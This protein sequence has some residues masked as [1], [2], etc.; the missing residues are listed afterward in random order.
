MRFSKTL[1]LTCVL[2]FVSCEKKTKNGHGVKANPTEIFREDEIEIPYYEFDEFE[3]FLSIKDAKIYVI[4]FWATWCMPCVEELP[5]F[6]TINTS[7]KHKNVE[8]ILV[9]L[10]QK[11]EIQTRLFPFIKKHEIRSEVI[12]LNG[13][14]PNK[15]IDKVDPNW[16]GAIPITIIYNKNKR[17][18]YEKTFTLEELKNEIEKFL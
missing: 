13:V 14:N 16:S 9:S 12:V 8:V 3:K 5:Y 15:W 18:F 10:D 1:F 17:K 6:E 11:K 2:L 7:Y 4:N